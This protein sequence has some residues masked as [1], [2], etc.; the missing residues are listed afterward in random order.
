MSYDTLGKL[1]QSNMFTDTENLPWEVKSPPLKTT[2]DNEMYWE[3][4]VS[5]HL[6]YFSSHQALS[7]I[8]QEE[9]ILNQ[10]PKLVKS[11]I[12]INDDLPRYVFPTRCLS[13]FESKVT[14]SIP[15]LETDMIRITILL[16][17]TYDS[18]LE[19]KLHLCKHF[20]CGKDQKTW[21]PHQFHCFWI[22]VHHLLLELCNSLLI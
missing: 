8:S 18:C 6:W 7:R 13:G 5:I 9:E 21:S 11:M 14:L 20:L 15:G 2:I 1:W 17:L 12:I 16:A 3:C 10:A 4:H 19:E 22:K